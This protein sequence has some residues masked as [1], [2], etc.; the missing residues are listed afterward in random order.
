MDPVSPGAKLRW[1]FVIPVGY[2]ALTFLWMLGRWWWWQPA[3]SG[4]LSFS[5]NAGAL[6]FIG[7]EALYQGGVVLVV[8]TFSIALLPRIHLGRAFYVSLV[9]VVAATVA[10]FAL[11]YVRRTITNGEQLLC[12]VLT[13]VGVLWITGVSIRRSEPIAPD[14]ST[15]SP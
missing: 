3:E 12:I 10:S 8:T 1:W 13:Y 15:T 11:I 4:S 7:K 9:S 2:A 6:R 5:L 14:T